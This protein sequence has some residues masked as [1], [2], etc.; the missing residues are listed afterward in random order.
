M[1]PSP[2]G[3]TTYYTAT[4]CTMIQTI[5]LAGGC[6]WGAQHFLRQIRG[7]SKTVVGFANGDT[8]DPTYKQV[9]TDT[10]GYSECVKVSFDDG[11]LPLELLL[12]LYFT[13]IDP[14]S[15]NHQGE[16]FGTRYRTGIYYT[17]DT[18]RAFLPVI[19]SV[20]DSVLR[21][22]SFKTGKKVESLEV[23]VLPLRNFY[24]AEEFHQDYLINNPTG[25][26]H[27][28]P[29]AFR[30]AREANSDAYFLRPAEERDLPDAWRMLHEAAQRMMSEG[31]TQWNEN[32]PNPEAVRSD[33][34]K[35][36]GYVLCQ[37]TGDN[38]DGTPLVYGAA[39][40]SGEK[41]YH[42]LLEG[43]WKTEEPYVV[44]HRIASEMSRQNSGLAGR[45][46]REVASM[47]RERGCR[48]FRIDTNY[49]NERMI[50][51]LYSLGFTY[52]GKCVY[53]QG[54]RLCF[55]KAL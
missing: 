1:T 46:L 50:S 19:R 44:V 11:V 21:N 55:E 24:S 30:R 22:L 18:E 13:S 23:E 49:D 53:P 39:I 43:E 12:Q 34:Q 36:C 32:Y 45:F 47:S 52:C 40:L 31:K 5:Y 17:P 25:Y 14:L 6:F 41:A 7:V 28:G 48:S 9:Y 26:C 10:T 2:D 38:P 3:G 16:D 42:P 54:G 37:R 4:D 51:L 8:P 29:A 27:L 33:I 15:L 20:Y 35:G